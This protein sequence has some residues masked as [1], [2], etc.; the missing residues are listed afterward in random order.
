MFLFEIDTQTATH[1]HTP[2]QT[3]THTHTQT[4]HIK[5]NVQLIYV[6]LAQLKFAY[7]FNVNCIDEVLN[8]YLVYGS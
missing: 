5:P 1:T 4:R 2:A 3:Q 8:K 7:Y 6:P